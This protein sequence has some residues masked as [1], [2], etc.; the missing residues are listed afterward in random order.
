MYL[1]GKSNDVSNDLEGGSSVETNI[2]ACVRFLVHHNTY[3]VSFE[4]QVGS[5][6]L[7]HFSM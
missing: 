5:F 4:K 6:L 3:R 1:L 7:K 2:G